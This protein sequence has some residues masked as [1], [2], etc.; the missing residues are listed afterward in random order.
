[1][2]RSFPNGI[3][4]KEESNTPRANKPSPP[5]CTKTVNSQFEMCFI[6]S[7]KILQRECQPVRQ[8]LVA[9]KPRPDPLVFGLSKIYHLILKHWRHP[10]KRNR[11]LLVA[12]TIILGG[13]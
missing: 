13:T 4:R 9:T 1:M 3:T 7:C 5:R 10:M 12:A 2:T 6:S 8:D 11:F